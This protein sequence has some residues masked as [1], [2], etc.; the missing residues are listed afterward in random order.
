[1]ETRTRSSRLA[2]VTKQQLASL[3]AINKTLYKTSNPLKTPNIKSQLPKTV[4]PPKKKS[5]R[6]SQVLSLKH[7]VE[8]ISAFQILFQPKI[9][10]RFSTS[11]AVSSGFCLP[12]NQPRLQ[13]L[14]DTTADFL[15][16]LEVTFLCNLSRTTTLTSAGP[17]LL[18][19]RSVSCM[20]KTTAQIIPNF[21]P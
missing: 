2:S 19:L 12:N 7:Q 8:T 9:L 6:K 3:Q 17:Q 18:S 4:P 20:C 1:M 5:V 16:P 13:L 11:R 10:G 14:A 15:S 21:C